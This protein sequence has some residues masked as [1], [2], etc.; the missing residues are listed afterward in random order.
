M[1]K[2]RRT[3]HCLSDRAEQ[4]TA[5]L[6]A[7]DLDCPECG[8][9]N[10]VPE[11]QRGEEASCSRC[12]HDLVRVEQRPFALPLSLAAAS[13]VVMLCVYTMKFMVVSTT[14]VYEYITLP[15]M[16]QTLIVHN[17]GFLAEVMMLF[18]FGTPVLMVLLC[19]YVF[20]ALAFRRYLPGLLYATRTLVKIR[21]WMMVDVFFIATLVAYIK[22]HSMVE[23]S[24]GAAFWLMFVLG[25]LLA[26]TAAAVPEHWVYYQIHRLQNQTPMACADNPQEIMCCSR[27][28]YFRPSE[29]VMCQVCGNRL[30]ARRPGSLGISSAFLLAAF[31]LYIPA[32][33]LP[34]MITANP[35]Q[36]EISTIMGGIMTMWRSDKLV[37]AII[38]SA[39]ILVPS[40]K[41]ISL[42]TLIA[43]ARFGL[44]ASA[45]TLSRLYR[46]TEMVGRW[47][48]IDIFVIIILMS[49]FHTPI[50]NVSPGPAALYF[51]LVVL[52]TM[53]SAHFFDPRLLWDKQSEQPENP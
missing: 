47:S 7:H 9:A 12:G 33:L 1:L 34:I 8:M 53:F 21:D 13:L 51:C 40:L 42:A 15:M 27:C 23:V 49:A 44:P 48:M 41:I 22:L 39:S 50:V 45:H 25:V 46:L 43:A 36:E 11:L 3:E 37:A 29:E 17:F 35:A 5:V 18:T 28:L 32:N 10:A 19:L 24:F 14:G 52:L 30:F 31:V 38:F 4:R 2:F 26:R 16:M 6:P 20:Y